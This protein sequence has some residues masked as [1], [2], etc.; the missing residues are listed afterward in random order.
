M[1][2]QSDQV[3]PKVKARFQL[4]L[5]RSREAVFALFEAGFELFDC[6]TLEED[7]AEAVAGE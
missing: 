7:A 1:G 5:E 3:P 6:P 2:R 4:A